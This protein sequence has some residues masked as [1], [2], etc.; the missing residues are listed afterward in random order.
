M[1]HYQRGDLCNVDI[2]PYVLYSAKSLPG[3]GDLSDQTNFSALTAR[4]DDLGEP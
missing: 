2:L 1:Q 3:C 4:V